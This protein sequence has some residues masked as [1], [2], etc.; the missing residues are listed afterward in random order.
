MPFLHQVQY[1]ILLE[2]DAPDNATR[3]STQLLTQ[4]KLIGEKKIIQNNL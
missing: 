3:L 2:F 4:K 1:F